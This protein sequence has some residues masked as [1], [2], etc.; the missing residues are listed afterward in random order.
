MSTEFKERR[1][2]V[3]MSGGVDSSVAAAVL[4]EQGY[5]VIGATMRVS[6]SHTGVDAIESASNAAARLGIPH[7]VWEGE[8]LF[9]REIVG[10]FVSE[11]QRGRTP[12]P[13]VVCNRRIKFGAFRKA[14]ADLGVELFATGHYVCVEPYG[15]RLALRRG[16]WRP[17]DQSYVLANLSQEQLGLCLF[18]LGALSKEEVRA[19]AS[20]MGLDNADR[21]E[22]QEICFIPDDDYRAFLTTRAG[23]QP[24]GP[25]LNTSGV[26]IGE[27]RGLSF[28]TVGQ[29][30][31][32]GI[33]APRPLYVIKIDLVRNAL[34]VGFEEETARTNLKTGPV[35]WMALP[36]QTEPFRCCAQIRYLHKPA[37]ATALPGNDGLEIL[38]DTPQRAVS[39][40]QF[41][42]LYDEEDHVLA[43][44]V[45]E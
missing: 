35:N 6:R 3:A 1:V 14:F 29:R 31:G 30:R 44:A 15:G 23:V 41:C 8:E 37:P 13:C 16:V 24:T 18:P 5:E 40:G 19:R 36:P 9:D 11:Y 21:P 7:H 27:H 26:V 43:G 45:I 34:I 2:L 10:Y 32:L 33:A 20:G 17:K 28:Y 12:N 39:P 38:F 42:V 22:S 4:L 25:I